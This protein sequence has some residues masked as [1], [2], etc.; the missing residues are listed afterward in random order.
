[1]LRFFRPKSIFVSIYGGILLVTLTVSLCTYAVLNYINDER[2]QAYT[3][4][5]ST[6]LFH[7]TAIAIARQDPES[8][9]LWVQ[10]A[11][12]LVG[13]PM[14]LVNALDFT[15]TRRERLRLEQGYAVARQG[16]KQR[17]QITIRVPL[18]GTS[19]YLVSEMDGFGERQAR[20]AANFYLEDLANYP[21]QESVRLRTLA[22]FMGFP[23]VLKPA[24]D[25]PLDREQR[26]RLSQDE[27]VVTFQELSSSGRSSITVIAPSQSEPGKLLVIGPFDLFERLP[28]EWLV[29]AAILA[30]LL[31]TLGS[32]GVIHALEV[33]LLAVEATVKKLREGDLTAR[34]TVT[35]ADEIAR[36][37]DTLNQMAG[38]TKRLLDSQRELTQAVSH[39]LRTP[40][41]RLRFGMEMMAESPDPDDRLQQ[42]DQLDEDIAQLNQLIDEI[43]TYATL[44]QGTPRLDFEPVD[45]VALMVRI[46]RETEAL[47]K[48][49]QLITEAEP[50]LVADAVPRYIHRVIQN[51]V[52]NALRY[53]DKTV[54][55]S[56]HKEGQWAV[57]TVED[58]G[59]GIPEESR[60]RVFQPFTRLD[61]SRTR[62]TG[63]YGLGLSIVSRIVYW[64]GGTIRVDR[65][66]TLG[67]ARFIMRW[68]M[69]QPRL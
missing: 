23:M 59:P 26:L 57:L 66:E 6:A 69:H 11:E 39:E 58:D 30:L 52:G 68:P 14:R 17:S 42:L 31:I 21:G 55:A 36:L 43:L 62:S 19:I 65:S 67:G 60:D 7:I 5:M 1:M 53:A 27:V 2:A 44:E 40:L 13:A 29:L 41:A 63:G 9:A 32:Y 34:V 16:A 20:A 10:D 50:G 56:V 25:V 24:M 8:R 3:E 46:Q 22:P 47:R 45:M 64:F 33:K 28:M 51:L 61:D 37:A 38:H 15:P 4:R 35:G 12:Q 49:A 48:P 54:K 18:P